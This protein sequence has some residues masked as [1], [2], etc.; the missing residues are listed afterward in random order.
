MSL[1][2]VF[3]SS[4]NVE[5]YFFASKSSASIL[6]ISFLELSIL[7]ASSSEDF[8]GRGTEYASGGRD[9]GLSVTSS[10]ERSKKRAT[11]F[12]ELT[13]MVFKSFPIRPYLSTGISYM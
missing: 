4:A 13:S 10:C 2:R 6:S 1:A 3:L 12:T 11:L 8:S 9:A 5:A 7:M